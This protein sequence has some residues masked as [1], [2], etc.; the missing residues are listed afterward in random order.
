MRRCGIISAMRSRQVNRR[1]D[2]MLPVPV[3]DLSSLRLDSAR[4]HDGSFEV[5]DDLAEGKVYQD[6]RHYILQGCTEVHLIRGS[7]HML[8][9]DELRRALELCLAD[10]VEF[11]RAQVIDR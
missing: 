1:C 9:S 7:D 3:L 2:K 5:S 11:V 6:G 10:G 4:R 8:I